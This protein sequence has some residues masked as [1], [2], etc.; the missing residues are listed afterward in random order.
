MQYLTD[1][2]VCVSDFLNENDRYRLSQVSQFFKNVC[3]MPGITHISNYDPYILPVSKLPMTITYM[4]LKYNFNQPIVLPEKL[5]VLYMN[6]SYNHPIKLPDG[7]SLYKIH[8]I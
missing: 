5:E 2:L 6:Y 3:L 8:N 4:S 1:E 7:C